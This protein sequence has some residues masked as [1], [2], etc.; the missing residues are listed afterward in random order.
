MS[1]DILDANMT[2]AILISL[3]VTHS[4][5]AFFSQILWELDN[6]TKHK[7]HIPALIMP[8]GADAR[9]LRLTEASRFAA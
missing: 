7:I 8:N 1:Y 9:K 3:Q 5:H 6:I 4:N 2:D